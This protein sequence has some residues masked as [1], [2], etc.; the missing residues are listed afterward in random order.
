MLRTYLLILSFSICFVRIGQG[1]D[2]TPSF[3][4]EY[5]ESSPETEP[6]ANLVVESEIFDQAVA[7]LESLF[8]LPHPIKILFA[9][10]IEGPQYYQGVIN[11]PYNF[12]AQNYEMLTASNFSD[13]PEE[14]A[15][16]ILNLTEFV[17]YHEVGHALVD[18]LDIPVLGKHEDAVDG[19]AAI[20]STIWD[21]DE[22]A[23]SAADVMNESAA[24]SAGTDIT[25]AE[26]WDSHS[27]DEQRMF[28]IFCLIHGSS[29][30]EYPSLLRDI[31]MPD[32]E[33]DRCQYDY[34]EAFRNWSRVLGEHIRG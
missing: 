26:F 16:T 29:P 2:N 31:G 12:L 34:Q 24:L 18:I 23:L 4:L 22:I 27:L 28:T 5:H 32:E 17:L 10:D 21:L 7:D 30:E 3:I 33:S 20:L 11:M 13:D 15:Q 14:V 8:I 6:Y 19:F 25:D 9:S 1:Q